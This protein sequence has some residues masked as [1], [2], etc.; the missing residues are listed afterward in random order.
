MAVIE[1]DDLVARDWLRQRLQELRECHSEYSWANEIAD[2]VLCRQETSGQP[3][4]LAEVLRRDL[5]EQS[6]YH[7]L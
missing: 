2:E 1:T 7:E 6:L 4:D 3:V 5:Y